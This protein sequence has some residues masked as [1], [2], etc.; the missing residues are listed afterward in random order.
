MGCP[1]VIVNLDTGWFLIGCIGWALVM[2]V[3]HLLFRMS[4]E[5]DRIAR[6]QQKRLDPFSDVTI[7]RPLY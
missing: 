2:L 7:T 6:R 3:A 4:S 5:Q 1:E